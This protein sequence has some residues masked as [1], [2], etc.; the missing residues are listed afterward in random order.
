ME[1]VNRSHDPV[2]DTR[3]LGPRWILGPIL[4][5]HVLD[6]EPE[7]FERLFKVLPEI[8]ANQQD[9]DVKN[10]RNS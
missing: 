5:E 3:C 8:L 6:G 7:D 1:Y 10:H 2:D 9:D 4:A